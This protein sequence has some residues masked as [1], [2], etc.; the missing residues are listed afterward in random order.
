MVLLFSFF[1]Y[2]GQVF[3]AFCKSTE[4]VLANRLH[5]DML[6]RMGYDER[7]PSSKVKCE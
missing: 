5:R 2:F 3:E 7:K 6:L 4:L 1:F